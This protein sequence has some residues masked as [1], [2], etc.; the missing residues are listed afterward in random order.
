MYDSLSYLSWRYGE[1]VQPYLPAVACF[2]A[3]L[4]ACIVFDV[5]KIYNKPTTKLD[6]KVRVIMSKRR[7]E[8]WVKRW[9]QYQIS[10]I[11]EE[12]YYK[13]KITRE[14]RD[15]WL[16]RIGSRCDMLDLLPKNSAIRYPDPDDLKAAI[17]GRVGKIPFKR[18]LKLRKA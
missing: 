13:G 11:A 15:F 14:E 17:R 4:L 16:Q 7:R 2:L 5:V 1:V 8:K 10:E 6:E 12:G 3:A 9:M 18:M